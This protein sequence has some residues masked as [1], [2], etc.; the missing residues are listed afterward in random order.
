MFLLKANPANTPPIISST[1]LI[2]IVLHAIF[3]ERA[4]GSSQQ[5]SQEGEGGDVAKETV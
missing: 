5:E 1:H 2:L 3:E 4:D